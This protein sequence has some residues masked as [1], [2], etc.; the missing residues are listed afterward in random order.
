M[1]YF[2][3]AK[4]KFFSLSIGQ[5]EIAQS[6]GALSDTFYLLAAICASCVVMMIL[7]FLVICINII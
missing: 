1:A 6:I 3:N 2:K 7:S 4:S 5:K